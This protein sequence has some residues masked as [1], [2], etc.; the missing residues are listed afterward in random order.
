MG[1][2]VWVMWFRVVGLRV[3]VMGFRVVGLR[4]WGLQGFGLWG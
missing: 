2:R 4:V 3:W 1:F